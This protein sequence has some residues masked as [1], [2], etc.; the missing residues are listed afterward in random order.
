M[1]QLNRYAEARHAKELARGTQLHK[2][3]VVFH[4]ADMK[5]CEECK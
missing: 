1:E 3:V 4:G 5:V 2:L